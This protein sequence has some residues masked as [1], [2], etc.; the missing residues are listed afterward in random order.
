MCLEDMTKPN[1][2]LIIDMY[3]NTV[4]IMNTLELTYTEA[5]ANLATLWD[6]VIQDRK[7]AIIHRR[8]KEDVAML[9]ASE[10]SGLME[11]VHLLRSPKNAE[12]LLEAIQEMEDGK[13]IEMSVDELR[14]KYDLYEE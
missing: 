13:G 7:T 2:E 3:R 6:R 8:G 11:T 5:R 4:H 14:A 1:R 10:L 12:R 9:P